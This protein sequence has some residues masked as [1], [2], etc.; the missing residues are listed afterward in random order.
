M[1]VVQVPLLYSKVLTTLA[2]YTRVLVCSVRALF[3]QTLFVSLGMMMLIF[4]SRRPSSTSSEKVL[5]MIY[6]FK[7]NAVDDVVVRNDDNLCPDV[8]LLQTD[9]EL[10]LLAC[11]SKAVAQSLEGILGVGHDGCILDEEQLPDEYRS[12]LRFRATSHQTWS[13]DRRRQWTS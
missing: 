13:A 6:G 9:S 4:P 1:Y 12:D 5:L 10:K 11:I 2:G 8:R 7:G 3:S